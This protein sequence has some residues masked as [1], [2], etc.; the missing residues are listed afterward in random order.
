M[1][2]IDHPH[3]DTWTR[4]L[5]L[6]FQRPSVPGWMTLVRAARPE[7]RYHHILHAVTQARHRGLDPDLLA[8]CLLCSGPTSC[9]LDLVEE[10]AVRPALLAAYAKDAPRPIRGLWW[11]LAAQAALARGDERQ[12]SR[13]L[14][15]AER[16]G[17]DPAAVQIVVG[18]MAQAMERRRCA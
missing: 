9:L 17:G 1:N 18:R 4:A 12:A 16:E 13:L 14:A 7:Q 8:R 15:R 10:G 2:P 6:F 3:G 5:E 11:A